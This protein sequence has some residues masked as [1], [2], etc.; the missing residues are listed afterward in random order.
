MLPQLDPTWYASQAAWMLITFCATFLLMWKAVLPRISSVT[1]ERQRRLDDDMKK[2]EAFKAEA[3]TV[4]KEYQSVMASANERARSILEDAQK[5]IAEQTKA[6]EAD[7]TERLERRIAD[8]EKELNETKERV[9]S[10]VRDIAAGLVPEAVFKLSGIRP[11]EKT[12]EKEIS[13][14]V[15]ERRL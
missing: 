13:E 7:F 10:G 12:A 9:L 6:R 1:D 8:G 14:I 15:K 2:A 11:A 5:E 3:E 4:L